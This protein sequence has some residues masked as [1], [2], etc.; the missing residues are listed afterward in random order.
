MRGISFFVKRL[1]PLILR[2]KRGLSIGKNTRI[3]YKTI[4]RIWNSGNIIIGNKTRLQSNQRGA[5]TAKP[6]PATLFVDKKN[7]LIEIGDNSIIGAAYIHAQKKISIGNKCVISSGVNIMDSNAHIL[8][9]N[10]R[11]VGRDEPKEIII[12]NNVWIALNSIVLKGTTI[13]DN[14]VVAAGSVVKGIFPE[15]SLIQ[16]N[17]AKVIKQ[18]DILQDTPKFKD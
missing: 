12:G 11:T 13:G 14:C 4:V 18:L 15:N 3:D 17:P 9:S 2:H 8:L 10:N 16:G 6:F 5:H 7:A 1:Y